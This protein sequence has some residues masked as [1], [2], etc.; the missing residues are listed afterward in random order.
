VVEARSTLQLQCDYSTDLFDAPTL[1]RFV[2]NFKV[3]LE[4]IVGAP[5]A[6]VSAL[7]VR[8]AAERAQLVGEWNHDEGVGTMI[9]H[10]A[11]L[12]YTGRTL[13]RFP[14]AEVAARLGSSSVTV[15]LCYR[16]LTAEAFDHPALP[17]GLLLEIW[18]A[19]S[20]WVRR[21]SDK[22]A[23]TG[24]SPRTSRRATSRSSP[25]G[26]SGCSR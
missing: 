18:A 7:P 11:I 24:G 26:G 19:A 21:T 17:R 20:G 12:S 14:L 3:L 6:L 1:R 23:C 15:H 13:S 22:G 2:R 4:G 25:A 10:T 9:E 8:S 16:G 5:G